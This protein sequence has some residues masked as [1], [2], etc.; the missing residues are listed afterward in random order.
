VQKQ[1][2]ALLLTLFVGI[3]VASQKRERVS[4]FASTIFTDRAMTPLRL[5][6]S[7]LIVVVIAGGLVLV[8]QA[9]F[10]FFSLLVIMTSLAL[11]VHLIRC[12]N[13]YNKIKDFL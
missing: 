1:Y 10:N 8:F 4:K 5:G 6:L 7:R 2:A 3:L 12:W 9:Y 11:A 13:L